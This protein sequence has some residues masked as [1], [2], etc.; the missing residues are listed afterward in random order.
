MVVNWVVWGSWPFSSKELGG[1]G[2]EKA[3][4]EA[5]LQLQEHLATWGGKFNIT[6][7]GTI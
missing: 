6:H 1:G 3:H 2:I 4:P 5:N 7:E